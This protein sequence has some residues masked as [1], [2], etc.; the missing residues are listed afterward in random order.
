[1]NKAAL[2]LGA[3]GVVAGMVISRPSSA[4]EMFA[5]VPTDHWAYQAVNN[6]QERGIVIGYPDGTFGGKRAMTRYEFAVAID[7]LVDWVNKSMAGVGNGNGLTEDQVRQMIDD[8][9]ANV[10][11]K[12]DL[13]NLATKDDLRNLPTKEDLE[14]IQRL[15]S[16]F[17]D[18]L[19]ALGTNVD[20]LRRDLDSLKARVGAIEERLDRWKFSGEANLIA[21][22]ERGDKSSMP[23]ID[24]P[25]TESRR[26]VIDLDS[27]TDNNGTSNI[28]QDLKTLYSLD[29][30]VQGKLGGGATANVLLNMGNYLPWVNSNRMNPGVNS[31][32]TSGGKVV[33]GYSGDVSQVQGLAMN[34][35]PGAPLGSA[36]SQQLDNGRTITQGNY[37]KDA[38]NSSYSEI[39]P[40]KLNVNS[41]IRDLLFFKDIDATIGKFGVQFTPY[42]LRSVD[43]DSYT[44][45]TLTDNG[46]VLT[47]GAMARASVGGLHLVGYAGT[48]Y[49]GSRNQS[50]V[51]GGSP[52]YLSWGGPVALSA[53]DYG[54]LPF[55]QS[56][57]VHGN[58]QLGRF[59]IGGTYIT[60]GITPDVNNGN[61]ALPPFSDTT[62]YANRANQNNDGQRMIPRRGEV[63]GGELR[64]PL[65]GRLSF[66]GE[67][68]SSNV[69]AGTKIGDREGVYGDNLHNAYDAKLT[70]GA[71]RLNLAGGYKQVDPFFGAPGDWGNIGRW[72]NPNNIQGWNASAGYNFGGFTLKGSYEDYNSLRVNLRTA[73][74]GFYGLA[75]I[76]A[77]GAGYA[78]VLTDNFENDIKHYTVGLSFNLSPSNAIDLGW[79]QARERPFD[80][81]AASGNGAFGDGRTKETYWNIGLGHRFNDTTSFKILYQIVDYKD[82][83]AGLYTVPGGEYKGGV[84]VTQLSVRF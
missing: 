49:T 32:P 72:K 36:F 61:P 33:N 17:K 84:G 50:S 14:T 60:A 6:L 18:E 41:P 12:D 52:V 57:G 74:P 67:F 11:T 76:Q 21:R 63:Y 4:A 1:M 78:P 20:T 53:I 27:R 82:N 46:E 3:A 26:P 80:W 34:T 71:G 29:F 54:A 35:G 70:W 59:T 22:G 65:F 2:W 62:T 83:G 8:R 9:L 47:T 79:E 66:A 28:L 30:G 37:G 25:G 24:A 16:E 56:M 45:V 64:F 43:P 19:S 68:A 15:V 7:R 81:Q 42:T 75:G 51:N 13:A 38:V 40:I 39:T 5:D 23:G 69:L 44:D 73:R 48:H 55:D 77:P 31:D 10:A 58:Y